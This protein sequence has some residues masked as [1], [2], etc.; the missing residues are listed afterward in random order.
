MKNFTEYSGT[1]SMTYDRS[2][3]DFGFEK[4]GYTIFDGAKPLL[5]PGGNPISH[6]SENVIRMIL[7]DLLLPDGSGSAVSIAPLI[8]SYLSDSFHSGEDPIVSI[9]QEILDNDPFVRI[10]TIGKS[11]ID[12]FPP[13]DPLFI[14]S[15]NTISGLTWKVNH[16]V[17]NVMGDVSL[18]DDSEISLFPHIVK[19]WYT[20]LPAA[21]K[22]SLQALSSMHRS[23][24]VLPLL[25]VTGEINPVEYCKGLISL[26]MQNPATYSAMLSEVSHIHAFLDL[27]GQKERQG[28]NAALMIQEGEGDSIE[29]KSTLRWDIRAGKTNPVI[30]RSC[31]KTISAFMNS[32]GGSLLIG[33]RDDGSIEG[34]ETDKFQNEDKFLLHLWTLIRNCLGREFTPYVSTRLEKIDDKVI[35]IVSCIPSNRPAFLRQPGFDEEMYIRVGPSS[36][37][38]D[39]S[40]ALRYIGDR[41]SKE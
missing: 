20:R 35:C 10:K 26:R 25:L 21:Q 4:S 6:P 14:F 39:I 8:F 12:A 27:F 5:T 1:F 19:I 32:S 18:S 16:F 11:G 22:A 30:E 24:I 2:M 15:F 37:A 31:L 41:F 29:Y 28:K 34:I 40:E 17:G 13:D 9:W 38:L 7:T 33:V 3:L 23:G 36:N